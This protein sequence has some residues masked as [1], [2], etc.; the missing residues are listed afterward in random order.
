LLRL[1]NIFSSII[2]KTCALVAWQNSLRKKFTTKN[3]LEEDDNAKL[4]ISD[5]TLPNFK[6]GKITHPKGKGKDQQGPTTR[7][8]Q[9]LTQRKLPKAQTHNLGAK[10]N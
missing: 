7:E 8:D 3:H 6:K 10:L 5:E 1:Y 4:F 2:V 9:R